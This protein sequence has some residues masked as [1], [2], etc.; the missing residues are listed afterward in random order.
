MRHVR[1]LMMLLSMQDDGR[2]G[3]QDLEN[4]A[5]DASLEA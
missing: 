5:R 1:V 2:I 4:L 3:A